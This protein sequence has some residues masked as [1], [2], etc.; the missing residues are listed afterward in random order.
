[1]ITYPIRIR[2]LLGTCAIALLLLCFTSP[3][4]LLQAQTV[5]M[6]DDFHYKT[7]N[8]DGH[9]PAKGVEGWKFW[10]SEGTI[11]TD[12][13]QASFITT[14]G[15]AGE[16]GQVKIYYPFDLAANTIYTLKATIQYKP[17]QSEK[18]GWMGLGF[19][20]EENGQTENEPWMFVD[21]Q[22]ESSDN[23]FAHGLVGQK[24]VANGT[25]VTAND[26]SFPI[27]AKITWNTSN[28]EVQYFL[29][30]QVQSDWTQ[31]LGP[32]SGRYSVFLN[33]MSSGQGVKVTNVSLTSEPAKK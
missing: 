1:M 16:E 13:T 10:S 23:G 20:A 29:N 33:A 4:S 27:V 12:G 7:D 17:T 26:Y 8:I 11:V 5:V 3:S 2:S 28:G 32:S 24:E 9:S 31:K 18:G 22:R 15:K 25:V 21:T 14:G 19:G 6:Q 30:D